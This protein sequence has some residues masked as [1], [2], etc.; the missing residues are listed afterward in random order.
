MGTKEIVEL[1]KDSIVKINEKLYLEQSKF[2]ELILQ[3]DVTACDMDQILTGIEMLGIHLVNNI[4]DCLLVD[5]KLDKLKEIAVQ[6][7]DVYRGIERLSL[8][9]DQNNR[10]NLIFK[11]LP[12]SNNNDISVSQFGRKHN[13]KS[14]ITLEMI[15][16]CYVYGKRY[17]AGLISLVCAREE[18][19]LKT[20]MNEASAQMYVNAVKCMLEGEKVYKKA[21]SSSAYEYFFENILK[22][23]GKQR[24]ENAI[25]IAEKHLDFLEDVSG[26]SQNKARSVCLKYRSKI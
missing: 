26:A 10:L 15:K 19:K 21:I 18:I 24:L 14:C 9:L 7:T 17:Y 2:D 23:F 11:I 3:L 25:N 16:E 22:D 4:N 5:Q 13:F 8:S 6:F 12:K 20:N 1:L